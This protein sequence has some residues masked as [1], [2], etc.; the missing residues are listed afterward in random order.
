MTHEQL[1]SLP[2]GTPLIL[3]H[4]GTRTEC[5]FEGMKFEGNNGKPHLYRDR[6]APKVKNADGEL[7]A[8]VYPTRMNEMFFLR[9]G[10]RT[11]LVLDPQYLELPE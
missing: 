11:E 2:V 7:V 6:K 9:I 5:V 3:N 4:N 10:R 1:R 8:P